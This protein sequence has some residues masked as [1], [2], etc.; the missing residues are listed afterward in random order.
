MDY[1]SQLQNLGGLSSQYESDLSLRNSEMT[2]NAEQLTSYADAFASYSGI[3]SADARAG[4]DELKAW[5]T[6]AG[7]EIALGVANK[8]YQGSALQKSAGALWDTGATYVKQKASSAFQSLQDIGDEA[9]QGV[10]DFGTVL[11]KGAQGIAQ[12]FANTSMTNAPMRT[13]FNT[14]GEP[15]DESGTELTQVPMESNAINPP[16]AETNIDNPEPNI[17]SQPDGEEAGHAFDGNPPDEMY[18]PAYEGELDANLSADMSQFSGIGGASGRVWSSNAEV[19]ADPEGDIQTGGRLIA[20][21]EQNPAN[22]SPAEPTPS[23]PVGDVA[24]IEG[25]ATE[26]TSIEGANASAVGKY[27]GEM[28]NYSSE[29]GT[30]VA[31]EAGADVA[32][33]IGA[34]AVEDTATAG[35]GIGEVLLVGQL[36]EAGGKALYDWIDPH[37]PPPP[38]QM[39]TLTQ[40]IQ[41]PSYIQASAQSGV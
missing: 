15:V 11:T 18:N 13:S 38:P 8:L 12:D 23:E 10:Q 9:L 36:L 32:E 19:E 20:P 35:T 25:V 6:Q 17:I 24:N 40:V 26:N 29:V 39:P 3:A 5:G 34:D 22:P 31:D 21:A 28:T 33:E 27:E 7:G 16:I 2:S 30:G 1:F 37:K 14:R 41:L 4:I